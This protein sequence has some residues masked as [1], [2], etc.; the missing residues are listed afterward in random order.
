[1]SHPEPPVYGPPTLEEALGPLHGPPTK[2]EVFIKHERQLAWSRDLRSEIDR[3]GHVSIGRRFQIT[4]RHYPTQ[5]AEGH[6]FY[7][8]SEWDI[9]PS[10]YNS[11]DEEFFALSEREFHE[12][13]GRDPTE[14]ESAVLESANPTQPPVNGAEN[15]RG[16]VDGLGGKE[17]EGIESTTLYDVATTDAQRSPVD[18]MPISSPSAKT[19]SSIAEPVADPDC[20]AGQPH[21]GPQQQNGST[22]IV[23]EE[24]LNVLGG[25]AQTLG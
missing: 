5:P 15:F 12:W 3:R 22:A 7:D 1:M 20:V 14:G 6:Y 18:D 21:E 2:Y 4:D 10:P 8:E 24:S 19:P 13:K 16:G 23:I 17:E 25:I 11:E 9:E